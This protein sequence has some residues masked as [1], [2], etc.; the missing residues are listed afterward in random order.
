MFKFLLAKFILKSQLP[1][2]KNS[3]VHSTSKVE[4]KSSVV[5]SVIG[6]HSF[7]GYGCEVFH[8]QVGNFVSIAND[9]KI[10]GGIHPMEWACSSPA[11]YEGKDSIKAKFSEYSRPDV[12]RTRIGSDVWIGS[13]VLVKQGVSIGHGSVVGMGSVVTKDVPEY[14]IVAGNP[15]RL[16]RYRFQEELRRRLLESRWWDCEDELIEKAACE[17]RDPDAFLMK[18]NEAKSTH[19]GDF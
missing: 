15:A 5:N 3:I 11:F 2:I 6:K 8:V 4:A 7:V 19:G 9:V 1:A 10:G 16:I 12:L 13:N 17:V 14:A 18:I